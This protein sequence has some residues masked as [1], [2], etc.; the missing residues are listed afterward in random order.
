MVS[1]FVECFLI[2]AFSVIEAFFIRGYFGEPLVD[3]FGDI[4]QD[5]WWMVGFS[6]DKPKSPPQ[7]RR[8]LTSDSVTL[9]L[10]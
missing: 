2:D 5:G 9:H 8:R 1:A 4:F 7:P 6:V 3:G 10:N